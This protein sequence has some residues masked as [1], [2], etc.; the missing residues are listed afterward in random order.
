MHKGSNNR[1][2]GPAVFMYPKSTRLHVRTS[3]N[4]SWNDGCDAKTQLA[5][6]KWSHV[7]VQFAPGTAWV[8]INGKGSSRCKI[9]NKLTLNKGDLYL[10]SPWFQA[11]NANI[12]SLRNHNGR[13]TIQQIRQVMTNRR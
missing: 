13:L 10:G 5:L 1:E 2:R 11:A 6:N 9:G 12:R 4:K 8:Y 7:Y 3:T